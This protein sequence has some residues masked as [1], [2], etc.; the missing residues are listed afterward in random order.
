MFSSDSSDC[1]APDPLRSSSASPAVS[2]PRKVPVRSRHTCAP[3]RS[4]RLR[5]PDLTS[6][7]TPPPPATAPPPL[8]ASALETGWRSRVKTRMTCTRSEN[9]D[10]WSFL[11]VVLDSSSPTRRQTVIVEFLF[12]QTSWFHAYKY[13][14]TLPGIINFTV[15]GLPP[16]VLLGPCDSPPSALQC[17]SGII[18][19]LSIS[20]FRSAPRAPQQNV[21]ISRCHTY[22]QSPRHCRV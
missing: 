11:E 15:A 7:I 9:E 3:W 13:H 19:E 5:R 16:L 17:A 1:N 20:S 18:F 4:S 12:N 21:S 6:S 2:I 14:A 8:F 22:H 10:G